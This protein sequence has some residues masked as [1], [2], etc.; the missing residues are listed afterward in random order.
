MAGARDG[1]AASN[2]LPRSSLRRRAAVRHVRLMIG[3]E[4]MLSPAETASSA[5]PEGAGDDDDEAER[6]RALSPDTIV[7]K[8]LGK[9]WL[10]RWAHGEIPLD[11]YHQLFAMPFWMTVC[12]L[13]VVYIVLN[14]IFAG[15]YMIGNNTGECTGTDGSYGRV[16]IFSVQTFST[17]G[18][19]TMQPLCTYQQVVMVFEAFVALLSVSLMTGLLFAKLAKPQARM[20]FSS[21]ACVPWT[22]PGRPC[23]ELHIRM[24]NLRMTKGRLLGASIELAVLKI[25]RSPDGVVERC[26]EELPLVTATNPVFSLTWTVRHRLDEN[27]PLVDHSYNGA[28]QTSDEESQQGEELRLVRFAAIIASLS[29]TEDLYNATVTER[30]VYLPSD[31]RVACY[32]K[33]MIRQAKDGKTLIADVDKLDYHVSQLDNFSDVP[34]D[35]SSAPAAYSTED[36]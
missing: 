7:K 14:L 22:R 25:V 16:L 10:W 18:Y 21:V 30:H 24:M 13:F 8:S 5:L 29:A 2:E 17:I 1:A 32:F 35:A 34:E 11:L 20:L 4:R 23:P 15:L 27:S 28:A 9:S 19:G 6:M 31:L 26:V 3:D 33:S 12:V 36:V